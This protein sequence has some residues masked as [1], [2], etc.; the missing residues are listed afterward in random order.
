MTKFKHDEFAKDLLRTI[1]GPRKN[2][3]GKFERINPTTGIVEED[4]GFPYG[5]R[6]KN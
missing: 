6:R 2:E 5:W 4:D 3:N 1:L